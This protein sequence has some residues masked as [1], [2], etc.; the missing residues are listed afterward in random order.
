MSEPITMVRCRLDGVDDVPA[1]TLRYIPYA[2]FGLWKHLMETK[3]GR[4]VTVEETSV[5]VVEDA[6]RW[7]SG[8]EPEDLE[9]VLHFRLQLVAREGTMVTIERYFPAESYPEAQEALL[10]HFPAGS[11]RELTAIPGYFVPK[12]VRDAETAAVTQL[13]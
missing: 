3:H 11:C 1:R 9:P 13:A 8:Y 7:N 6:A 2:E 10:S 12:R 5:W 4:T